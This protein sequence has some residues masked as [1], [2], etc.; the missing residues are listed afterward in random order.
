MSQAIQRAY[1]AGYRAAEVELGQLASTDDG[2]KRAARVLLGRLSFDDG[3]FDH[4]YRSCL[5]DAVNGETTDLVGVV[6]ADGVVERSVERTIGTAVDACGRTITTQYQHLTRGEDVW[7]TVYLTHTRAGDDLRGDEVGQ[8]DPPAED[9]LELSG[10]E[11]IRLGATLIDAG[12]LAMDAEA[13][14]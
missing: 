11:A 2:R 3:A 10:R 9:L 12:L 6:D 4:G 13:R 1:V 5:A 8:I 7:H 14:G